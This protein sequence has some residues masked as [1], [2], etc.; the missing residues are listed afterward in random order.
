VGIS[1]DTRDEAAR[2][3]YEPFPVIRRRQTWLNRVDGALRD[4]VPEPVYQSLLG[5]A[6]G[7]RKLARR[8]PGRGRIL[9]DFIIIGAAKAGTTSLYAWLCEHEFVRRATA[10][11]IHY[12]NLSYYRG[13]DWY[14]RHFPLER[15]RTAFA[16]KHGRPFLTGEASPRYMPH[17]LV[18]GRI[19]ELL[20]HVK[21]IV[22]L[23]DP[24]DRAYSQF[25][26]RRRDGEEPIESFDAALEME[27]HGFALDPAAA[28][29]AR[30]ENGHRGPG[31]E[32]RTYLSRGRYAEQL[33]RW[34]QHFPREQFHVLT[35]DDLGADPQGELDRV[36]EFLGLPARRGENL[37]ARF[38][39]AYE[40]MPVETRERL[41]EYFRQHNERLYELLGK[42]F[43]WES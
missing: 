6:N 13:T 23:R 14:R 4:H 26:M 3:G 35:M 19:A 41:V 32:W 38:T 10:K 40:P 24:S 1:N 29:T 17:E 42:N 15:E 25:Q 22:Q 2:P 34:F 21:L 11:E 5:G 9:P 28:L 20:P 37:T 27:D 8:N 30:R 33:E 18:P 16:A 39:A 12:F 7:L 36:H 43:G 31:A